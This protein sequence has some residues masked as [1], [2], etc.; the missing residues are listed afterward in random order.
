MPGTDL[1]L[2][3]LMLALL[4]GTDRISISQMEKLRH[5]KG[6]GLPSA[7]HT[8]AGH[9]ARLKIQVIQLE[10]TPGKHVPPVPM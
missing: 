1:V 8:T 4:I 3:I 2:Y 10:A 7:A 6:G 5:Q 9:T